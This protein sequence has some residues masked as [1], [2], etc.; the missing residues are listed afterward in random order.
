MPVTIALFIALAACT[1]HDN[2]GLAT[3]LLIG[4]AALA[5]VFSPIQPFTLLLAKPLTAIA[6]VLVYLLAG[7]AY[8]VYKWWSYSRHVIDIY[9]DNVASYLK[10]KGKTREEL[11]EYEFS[12]MVG[13]AKL[14][15][16]GHS[17]D[18]PLLVAQHKSMITG[19]M[20]YWPASAAWTLINDPVRRLFRAIYRYLASTLQG[21]SDSVF[22]DVKG[23]FKR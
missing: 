23:D 17:K 4:V 18:L 20:C 13:N 7:A 10:K 21:I 6:F 19:W 14:Q 16:V 22:A 12:D 11:S 9:N 2:P 8:S 1:E 3:I 15:A 5:Q